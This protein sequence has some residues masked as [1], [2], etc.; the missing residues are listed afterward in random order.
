MNIIKSINEC[1]ALETE[2][3]F[4]ENFRDNEE[5]DS[6]TQIIL[7]TCLEENFSIKINPKQLKKY[8]SIKDIF[9]DF[10]ED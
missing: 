4:E 9:D 8:N 2:L 10:S 3:K 6:M 7:L 1:L 5:W